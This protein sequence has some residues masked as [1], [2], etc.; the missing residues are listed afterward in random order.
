MLEL[1][2]ICRNISS[3][4][5]S[6]IEILQGKG[7]TGNT[8]QILK[9]INLRI[10]EGEFFS[11]LGPS[12][13]GKTSLLKIISG[14]DLPTSGDVLLKTPHETEL[15]LI[16]SIPSQQRPFHM[17]FQKHALFP[18]LNVFDNV[19]FGLRMK[20]TPK[21]E[22]DFRVREILKLVD[23]G[24][25]ED[26]QPESLSGGQSQRVALARAVVNR[27][28]ILLLDE[29]LSALD[30]KLR[31]QM[32][33]E[34]RRLQ[35]QLKMTFIYVTHDQEEAMSLSDRIG[36]MDHGELIEVATPSELYQNPRSIFAAEFIGQTGKLKGKIT[37]VRGQTVAAQVE[38]NGKH[39]EVKGFL[40]EDNRPIEKS[41]IGGDV[42]IYI[43]PENVHREVNESSAMNCLQCLTFETQYRGGFFEHNAISTDG[44]QNLRFRSHGELDRFNQMVFLS[45]SQENTRFFL[46]HK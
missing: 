28:Q 29:P 20:K 21:P 34:L 17:V 3:P 43:R 10:N 15:R 24:G 1:R 33:A 8:Q 2:N 42:N 36:I 4:W 23:L 41:L 19:A 6:Q 16:N 37:D 44:L 7:I 25:F 32:Q 18:H 27:P 5:P 12:G 13:C 26:R 46:E 11:L 14:I 35:R 40:T 31:I 45:F 9:N 39:F 22:I 30:Q 38:F